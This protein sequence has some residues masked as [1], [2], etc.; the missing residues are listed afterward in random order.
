MTEIEKYSLALLS[1]ESAEVGKEASKAIRF[2]YD[3]PAKE[4]LCDEIG[5]FIAALEYA[6]KR[7]LFN[8]EDVERIESSAKKKL[9]KLLDPNSTDNL[10]RRLAP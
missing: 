7:G 9:S 8:Q 1:E 3:T 10:G 2:G 6:T 5:D 4:S